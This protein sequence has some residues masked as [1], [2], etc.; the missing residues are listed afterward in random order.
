MYDIYDQ[1]VGRRRGPPV[2]FGAGPSLLQVYRAD[3]LRGVAG[4]LPRPA[5]DHVV[6]QITRTGRS[7]LLEHANLEVAAA[8]V[9]AAA[10]AARVPLVWVSARELVSSELA[11]PQRAMNAV[12][13]YALG[14]S[15]G[16][17]SSGVVYVH[18]FG[19]IAH[20]EPLY[21]SHYARRA[22][23]DV[24]SALHT[25]DA[26]R[27]TLLLMTSVT[28]GTLDRSVVVDRFDLAVCLD[29]DDDGLPDPLSDVA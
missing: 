20:P 13:R 23:H 29:V 17:Q 16:A 6:R 5:S 22:T 11:F 2:I 26:R 1:G 4:R 25:P 21:P 24:V 10:A 9:V 15:A 28:P 14:L 12:M 8:T 18:D 3:E 19:A 27:S 7:V